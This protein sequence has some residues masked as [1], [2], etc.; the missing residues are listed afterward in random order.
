MLRVLVPH[1]R[2]AEF[3]ALYGRATWWLYAG[4]SVR[5]NCCGGRFRRFRDYS[6][7]GGH[8]SLACP[9]CGAL[10]RHRVDWL[11]LTDRTEVL[12][13][14]TR[15]LH[16]APEVCL[17]TPLRRMP[18]VD[19]LSADFDSTL[20]M[21]RV[22]VRDI[23]YGDESFDG[24][25]CNHVLQLIDDDRGAMSELC[26]IVRP[27][28][29]A[30]IQSSVD[31]GLDDTIEELGAASANGSKR[32]EEV[33]HRIYGRDDYGRRLQQAG[34]EVTVSDFARDLQPATARELGL[35]LD[36]TIYFCRKP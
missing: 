28:G 30:L 25:I 23:Q 35:D 12:Q 10:G 8:R 33:F 7:E 4:R 36:E 17:E 18:N 22:D 34:F 13:R 3:K 2:R 16:I 32:Y 21:D 19:Y 24:V 5:C 11:Y 27:G 14:P 9:R 6:S 31:D 26:R 1:A 20:A 29:W 15:L